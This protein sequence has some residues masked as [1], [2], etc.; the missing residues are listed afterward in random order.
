MDGVVFRPYQLP[1]FEDRRSGLVVLHWSPQIGQS[2][3]LAA[4]AVD[5]LITRPGRLVTFLSNSRD[6]GAEFVAKCAEVCCL[7]GRKYQT[8]NKSL[9]LD[10]KD[11]RMEVKIRSDDKTGRIKVLAANPR[12]ARGFSG[13]LILDEFAFHEH[14]DA[15]WDAAEPILAS[16]PDFLCRIASTGNGRHN[17][18]YHFAEPRPTDMDG[19]ETNLPRGGICLSISKNGYILSR[20][21]RSKAYW[22]GVP[23]YDASSRL[24]IIPETARTQAVDK[25]SYRPKLRVRICR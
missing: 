22:L 2:F 3:V 6:N 8:S 13:D 7:Q 19:T 5:R 15:I 4:W 14:S 11:M 10:F 16:N 12:T 9:S 17:H 25:R 24:P 23:I 18:F 20:V 1:I 21:P